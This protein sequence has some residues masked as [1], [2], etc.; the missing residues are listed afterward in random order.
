M[1]QLTRDQVYA[2]ARK[3][4]WSETDAAT[5]TA[6]AYVESTYNT[7]ARN[8]SH[9]GLWQ[10]GADPATGA[11]LMADPQF[12]ANSAY[13]LWKSSG[14]N[15]KAFQSRWTNYESA[16]SA[17]KFTAE[18]KAI[19]KADVFGND[20]SANASSNILPGA[21]QASDA[22]NAAKTAASA[23]AS[24]ATTVAGFLGNVGA[25][26][27]SVEFWKRAGVFLGGAAVIIVGI[28]MLLGSSKTAHTVE[29][30]L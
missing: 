19:A 27:F 16:A 2:L 17:P 24:T 7:T 21:K 20:S 10:E 11:K 8:G 1:T 12:A 18:L 3:A 22:L 15:D 4:G 5:A 9:Y 25:V 29:A 30:G 6:I 14:A 23:A 26:V 28:V 13:A